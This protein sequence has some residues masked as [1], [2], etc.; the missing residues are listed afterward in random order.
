[1]I[2]SEVHCSI[3]PDSG[4]QRVVATDWIWD[5][6]IG[7]IWIV[8]VVGVVNKHDD[9][10]VIVCEFFSNLRAEIDFLKA[11]ILIAIHSNGLGEAANCCDCED[12]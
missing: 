3:A 11:P 12:F 9:A 10:R 7:R 1:M 6:R 2:V 4:W 8:D 5:D